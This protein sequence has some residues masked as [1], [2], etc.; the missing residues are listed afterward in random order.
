MPITLKPVTRMN[1]AEQ[2]SIPNGWEG[3]VPRETDPYICDI[4]GEPC[5]EIK[6][7][8]C[9]AVCP[10]CWDDYRRERLPDYYAAYIAEHQEQFLLDWWLEEMREE[11]KERLLSILA[12]EYKRQ[13]AVDKLIG[14]HVTERE[15][16]DFCTCCPE[17]YEYAESQLTQS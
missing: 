9:D 17:F 14:R 5:S 13:K 8:G 12:E 15:E 16:A 10:D 7:C 4:C 2:N 6:E 11:Q 1:V 3:S